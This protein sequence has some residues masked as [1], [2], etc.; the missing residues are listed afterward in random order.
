MH[1]RPHQVEEPQSSQ[2]CLSLIRSIGSSR[3][4]NAR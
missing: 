4:S 1:G 2:R 3:G